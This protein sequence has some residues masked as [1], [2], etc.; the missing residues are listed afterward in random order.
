MGTGDSGLSALPGARREANAGGMTVTT[1]EL[2]AA[3]E[4]RPPAELFRNLRTSGD[5][6]G[7]R[8]AARRLSVYGPNELS[9]HKGRSW[10][11]ELLAQF[12]Q[13]LAVLLMVAAVLAWLGG[14][15]A[16]RAATTG[17]SEEHTSEL[18]SRRDLVCRLLLE[19]KKKDTIYT[20][21]TMNVRMMNLDMNRIYSICLLMTPVAINRDSPI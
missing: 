3:D 4:R 15:P 16:T 20:P 6:L 5:G 12:T 21:R 13:P 9:G 1:G 18:Q 11:R 8:E 7:A 10:P 2:E 17:R 19:K 14:T